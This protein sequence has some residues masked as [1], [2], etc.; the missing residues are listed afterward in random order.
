MPDMERRRNAYV[1]EKLA[2]NHQNF[3]TH[4]MKKNSPKVEGVGGRERRNWAEALGGEKEV[5][6]NCDV[7]GNC[8]KSP[9]K[10][11]TIKYPLKKETSD[12]VV[13]ICS[14]Y[15]SLIHIVIKTQNIKPAT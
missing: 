4:T 2:V 6:G 9:L 14:F 12:G 15:F 10:N 13:L 1:R 3:M 8:K 11:K 7:T 5:R